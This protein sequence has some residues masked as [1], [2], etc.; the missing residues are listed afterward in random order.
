MRYCV[1]PDWMPYEA[2]DAGSHTGM[3]SDYLRLVAERAGL[4]LELL[5]TQSWQQTIDAL[6]TG[7]CQLS[8]MLNRSEHRES[9]LGFSDVYFYAPNVLVSRKDEPFLQGFT[10]I[11]DRLLALPQDY[12]LLEYVQKYYPK[13]RTL[14]VKS[15]KHGLQAVSEG[16][17][18]LFAGSLYSVNAHI[19]QAA[20]FNLKIAGWGGPQDELRIGVAPELTYLLP[21]LNKA[22]A[23][24]SE[25]EHLDIQQRWINL[26]IIQNNN[27]DLVWQV[28]A[29]TLAVLLLLFI[30]NISIR[31]YSLRLAT[32]NQQLESL[33]SQLE[34]TNAELQF[35]SN[36]DP[37]TKLYNR[38]YFN[39][40]IQQE[41]RQ[42][43][44]HDKTC[45]IILDIDHFKE[46]NDCH[47]HAC[48]DTILAELSGVLTRCVRDQDIVARWGGE[49]FV[50]LC[51]QTELSEAGKLAERIAGKVRQR[52][53][54][55]GLS[56]SCSFGVAEL[57][58][59]ENMTKC[60]ERA[61]QALYEA[62]SQGRDRV[63]VSH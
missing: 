38:H 24:I 28:V 39:L 45:L 47:G 50:I 23:S 40:R 6:K 49:E 60:L 18:D 21:A 35:L 2:I 27:Y 25:E 34:D 36:H 55:G 7:T 22:L 20:L 58:P 57:Q 42:S 30:W 48:G 46:I 8:P 17:A 32:K 31:R 54:S 43:Q 15:E 51:H 5:P 61:D 33:R 26:R 52:R 12:R 11:G 9:Y 4:D 10:N 62:K 19:Q 53:F 16:K 56:L 41:Q 37:L 44:Q 63:C 29:V 1:D 13:I 59:R 14:V 3:A